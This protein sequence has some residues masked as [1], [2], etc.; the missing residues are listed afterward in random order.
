MSIYNHKKCLDHKI[1][2]M[3][4]FLLFHFHLL[5]ELHVKPIYV[6]KFQQNQYFT[7]HFHVGSSGYLRI[8]CLLVFVTYLQFWVE[9]S[10]FYEF[11]YILMILCRK[12]LIMQK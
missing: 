6:S 12:K 10:V 5:C 11:N 7:Y 1:Y 8:E 3:P 2:M 9:T 4:A